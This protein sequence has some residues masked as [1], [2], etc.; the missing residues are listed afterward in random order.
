VAAVAAGSTIAFAASLGVTAAP[1]TS[2]S[3]S[4]TV[5]T[6]TCTAGPTADTYID[7]QNRNR[8][9]GGDTPLLV[10][11]GARP[12][13]PLVVFPVSCAPAGARVVS[14]TVKLYL[15]TAPAVTRTYGAY[16]ITSSWSAATASWSNQPSISSTAS[17]TA[18][19]GAS[20]TWMQWDLTA[21]VEALVDGAANRGWAVEDV[22]AATRS[23]SLDSSEGANP[24]TLTI[25]YW[26]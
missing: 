8:T 19:T 12:R 6:S 10:R 20:G 25:V 13:I 5:P 9:H 26:P 2:Y 14:A 11:S 18:V 21:D 3:A 1:L 17:A 16:P 22:G 4:S 15:R 24:P 7:A 23:G